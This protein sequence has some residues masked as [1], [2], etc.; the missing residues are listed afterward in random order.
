MKQICKDCDA[1]MHLVKTEKM[2]ISLNPRYKKLVKELEFECPKCHCTR[3]MW[4]KL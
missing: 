1:E 3:Y 4:K 2:D